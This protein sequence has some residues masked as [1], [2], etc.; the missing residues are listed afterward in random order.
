[1]KAIVW[2]KYGPPDGLKLCEVDTPSPRAHE[3]LIKVHAATA[4]TPDTEFRR[5]KF[6]L[7]LSIPLRL[8]IGVSKPIRKTILG[9][10]F[11]GEVVAVGSTVTRYHPGEALFGYTALDMGTYA[12]YVC[13]GENSIMARKPVNVGYEEA[14]AI[15]FGALEALHTLR[16][17]NIRRGQRVCIVGA[18]GS[19]GTYA[20]QLAKHAGAEVIGVDKAGK[21]EM[22]RSIGV[23][24]FIDYAREDFTKTGPPYDVILDTIDKT[25]FA[26][27]VRVLR[28]NGVYLNANPG[29]FSGVR[30]GL[31][32]DGSGKRILR[33]SAGYTTEN[34]QTIK[35]LVEAGTIRPIIDRRYPLEQTAEAHRYV[36]SGQKKG[37]VVITIPE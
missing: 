1:M 3:V 17:A 2:T 8:Y 13:L 5:M 15:P 34:M 35:E 27:S 14:A 4:S 11:A 28:E 26:R 33:W 37:N 25:P 36:D 19:I 30:A 16:K 10:E 24:H 12:E 21:A 6:P 31:S 9:S 29:L 18:G 32:A 22:L 23:D 7:Q 20:V